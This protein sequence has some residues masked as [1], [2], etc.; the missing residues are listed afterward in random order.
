MGQ[1]LTEGLLGDRVRIESTISDTGIL[2]ICGLEVMSYSIDETQNN[3]IACAL[4]TCNGQE[5]CAGTFSEPIQWNDKWN[6]LQMKGTNRTAQFCLEQHRSNH[7]SFFYKLKNK[8]ECLDSAAGSRALGFGGS[9][10]A[11]T[12]WEMFNEFAVVKL[13]D[14]VYNCLE[15]YYDY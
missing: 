1:P 5:C 13:D 15:V 7:D 14:E 11:R 9:K 4:A 3:E 6:C 10:A 8:Y 12:E 2:P